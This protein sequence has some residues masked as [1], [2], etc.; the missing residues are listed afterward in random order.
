MVKAGIYLLARLSPALAETVSWHC[1]VTLGGAA[2]MVAGAVLAFAQR[3]LKKILAYSTV[4]ALGTLALLL[5]LNTVEATK[6]GV[7]FLIVH[8]MYKGALFMMA[9]LPPLLGFISKELIYDAKLQAPRAQE[10]ITA[11]GVTANAMIVAVACML[12]LGPFYGRR[13]ET[14]RFAHEAPW[15]MLLGPALLAGMG[16][17]IGMMPGIFAAPVVSAAVAALHPGTTGV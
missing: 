2:A 8:S 15:P 10:Y 12:A 3:D 9:G 17:I 11:L 4:S 13:R 7:V 1:L 16:V 14:P 6:A 5:G